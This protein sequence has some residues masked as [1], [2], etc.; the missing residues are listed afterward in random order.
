MPMTLLSNDD[1]GHSNSQGSFIK[2]QRY[3]SLL[4]LHPDAVFEIDRDSRIVAVNQNF[5][6][7]LGTCQKTVIGKRLQSLTVIEDLKHFPD[8]LALALKGEQAKLEC[9]ILR[10]ADQ[11]TPI[12]ITLSPSYV[13]GAVASVYGIAKDLVL[14]RSSVKSRVNEDSL[15]GLPSRST[16]E[17]RI[18]D[19]QYIGE[20]LA[21]V[22]IINLDDFGSVNRHLGHD[23]GDRLLQEAAKR[24]NEGLQPGDFLARFAGDEFAL[25][26]PN[27]AT[28]EIALQIA[29]GYLYLLSCPF[30][31]DQ[32]VLQITASIGI[33]FHH[34]PNPHTETLIQ[35]ACIAVTDAKTQGRNTWGWYSDD[36]DSVVLEHISLR[37]DLA[38]AIEA[39][40]LVLH[41]QPLVDARTGVI[42]SLEALV[43]WQ[44]SDRGLM[45]PQ[46]FIS[47]AEKTGQIIDIERWVLRRAC[48]DIQALNSDREVPL[49]IAVNISS[50]HFGRNGFIEEIEHILQVSGLNPHHLELE[51][52]ES[53]LMTDTRKS[54]ER[55]QA[56]RS[57]GVR[58]AIDDFGTGYS[59]LAYLHRFPINKIKIDQAFIRNI[60][61]N[62]AN[63][64]IV[65]GVITMAH[66]LDLEVVA[67]GIETADHRNHLVELNCD[68]LQGYLFSRA[69]PFEQIEQLPAHLYDQ[70]ETY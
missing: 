7:L 32:H 24:I 61:S 50:A 6:N 22:L 12:E 51:V 45:S 40:R 66:R 29:E 31:I 42:R 52:T 70:T 65:E 68:T 63:A 33:A 44:H 25:L 14:Y 11:P 18:R 53:S 4:S 8:A 49:S 41:Y 60:D 16:F 38:D 20:Q 36:S 64:A 17:N 30:V 28:E 55:L 57:L 10:D 15:T 13:D 62:N 21:A 2:E 47:L 26:L 54:V 3:Q 5:E 37:R 34:R 48:K 39:N 19:T 35:R 23:I 56:L 46:E 43:R 27:I 59:N 9:K 67:E 1:T 58:I 69:L